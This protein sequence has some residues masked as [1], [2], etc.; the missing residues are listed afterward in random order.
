MQEVLVTRAASYSLLGLPITEN[1]QY[2][3]TSEFTV[4]KVERDGSL[5]IK[6]RVASARLSQGK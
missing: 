2:A 4:E 6:Q 5:I 3:F 1:V